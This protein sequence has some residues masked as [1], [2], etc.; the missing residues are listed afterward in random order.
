MTWNRDRYREEYARDPARFRAYNK[1]Q[2]VK[3]RDKRR[4]SAKYRSLMKLYGCTP[5]LFD[6]LWLVCGGRCEVCRTEL[7][8]KSSVQDKGRSAAV[9][10]DHATGSIRGLLCTNC[11][12]GIGH[13]RDAPGTLISAAE[14]L[15][16]A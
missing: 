9:D 3:H 12:I 4:V 8:F 15:R 1:R 11:N 13:F 10:H 5:A 6:V 16:S 7:N 14:Y 2:Y